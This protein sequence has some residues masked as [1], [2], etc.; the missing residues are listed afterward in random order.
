MCAYRSSDSIPGAPNPYWVIEHNSHGI[1]SIA[2]TVAICDVDNGHSGDYRHGALVDASHLPGITQGWAFPKESI[3]AS[4]MVRGPIVDRSSH[5]I[6][7]TDI[8][9]FN[10]AHERARTLQVFRIPHVK[11]V[12]SVCY[13]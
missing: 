8:R 1:L 7:L 6:R 3:T 5:S 4:K 11:K 9:L 13:R 10:L 12:S 2:S